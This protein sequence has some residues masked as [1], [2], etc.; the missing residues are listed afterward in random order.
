MK[1]QLFSF[2]FAGFLLLSIS[3]LAQSNNYPVTIVNGVEYFQ[4]T[5]EPSEGLLSI[6][7]KFDISTDDISKANP[8]VKNGLKSG[9]Q[10]LIPISKNARKKLLNQKH[11]QQEFIQHKVEKKQT[12]FSISRKYKISE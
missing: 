5:V 1:K 8:E 11:S 10:I 4:Y 7:R 9:Q 3:T 12:L 6:G 2:I